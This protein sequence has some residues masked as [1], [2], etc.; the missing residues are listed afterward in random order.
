MLKS[1]ELHELYEG[2][3]VND[4]NKYDYV[5]TGKQPQGPHPAGDRDRPRF[6]SPGSY[7][8]PASFAEGL[9]CLGTSTMQRHL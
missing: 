1:Q 4:V 5:L 8:V 7:L 6:P 9:G 2:L 3:K